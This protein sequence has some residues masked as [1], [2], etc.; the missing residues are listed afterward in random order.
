M[1]FQNHYH[2]GQFLKNFS[3]INLIQIFLQ[4]FYKIFLNFSQNFTKISKSRSE[5]HFKNYKNFLKI[6]VTFANNHGQVHIETQVSEHRQGSFCIFFLA[7]CSLRHAAQCALQLNI[8][9]KNCQ[10]SFRSF[11]FFCEISQN[12]PV[13]KL[14]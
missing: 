6:L 9:Q 11:N 8:Y 4:N 3:K 7:L 12:H 2:F 10:K 14:F 5:N 1:F 13:L